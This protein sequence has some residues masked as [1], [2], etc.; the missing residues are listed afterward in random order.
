MNIAFFS[1]L[2]PQRSGISDYS[3]ELLLELS[4]LVEVSL[5]VDGFRPSSVQL[6]ENFPIVDYDRDRSKLETLKEYDAV[7]Y[8][9]GNDHR[10]HAG[11]Y[12]AIK[13]QRGIIV[14][15]DF[16]LQDFFLGL[17]RER[18][19][20]NIYFDEMGVCHGIAASR[21]AEKA[22]AQGV[23]PLAL[24]RPTD[25]PLNCRLARSAEGIIV[26]SEWSRERFEKIAPGV[27]VRRISMPIKSSPTFD[28][29]NR[30][31]T[32]LKLASFG[33]I[34]P[35]KGI[36]Q[37]L[38]VLST[39]RDDCDFEY[40]LVGAENPYFDVRP[41]VETYHLQDR[42]RIT[43]HVSLEEF[44]RHIASTDI[45]L[46]LRERTVGET[47]ASLC[48]I[49]AAGVAVIVSN[50]GSF[51]E[52]PNDAVVKIEQDHLSDRLLRAYLRKLMDDPDLRKR[53]GANARNYIIAEHDVREKARYYADFIKEIVKGRA[54][55][56]FVSSIAADMKLLGI[57]EGDSLMTTLAREITQL[58]TISETPALNGH[59]RPTVLPPGDEQAGSGIPSPGLRLS[60]ISGIDYK[61]A[62]INYP[63]KL[64]AERY[65]Y[66][67][68]KP[69]YNLAN[70]PSKHLGE[71]M[72][73]ETF[74]HFCDFAN[75]AV[76]MAL[77]A[78]RRILD[79]G[80]GSGWLSEYFARLGY[81][82]TGIDISPDLIDIAN[83]R[84]AKQAFPVDHETEL[85]CRFMVHDIETEALGETFDAVVCYDSLHHFEDEHAVIR[86][87]SAMTTYGGVVF[88][89]E[90]DRPEQGSAT[91]EELVEVMRR[92]E[93]LES[94]FT[95]SYLRTLL[96]EN[97]LVV[98]GDYVSVNGL[99]ERDNLEFPSPEI[100][101]LL[102]K[103]VVRLSGQP[104]SSIPNSQQP[105][106][107]RAEILIDSFP[108]EV[109][110]GREI[111]TE[112]FIKNVGPALWLV[113][114]AKRVGSVML[115]L[116]LFDE[117]GGLVWERHGTPPLPYALAEGESVKLKM[118]FNVPFT[119]GIYTIKLDMVAQHVCWFEDAGSITTTAR[120]KVT[121]NAS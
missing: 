102:C 20:M 8:H 77:P 10:Y 35:G 14:F 107:L 101:Y 95:R 22:L 109:T 65:H 27:P 81:D 59:H 41:L 120:F 16:A 32:K 50:V 1:P 110:P 33:L 84:L 80:C 103:K 97:G 91:E 86:N 96:E 19:D 30:S 49:M 99:F 61:R 15:H 98:I 111:E 51:T 9:M 52:L 68:T 38:R 53:I 78:G 72:D 112:L 63:R 76:A 89:L 83:Q 56:K 90:G 47:S 23:L 104:A 119:P 106:G 5:F 116:R 66:L 11:I 55:R 75:M 26:H 108:S 18:K 48:R 3:E 62:A 69:F 92:Y 42:V 39:L 82:V 58:T 24:D 87:L 117:E 28:T 88:I 60:K 29:E 37:I 73:A 74:R 93:T 44:K 67:F 31:S 118:Q 70:K 105:T 25:F 85:R 114:A 100:N 17:A 6:L 12:D 43:G 94:P 115:G 121:T 21:D 79:V 57:S 54:R 64:D 113:G 4:K 46:N 45:A 34:I 2:N 40:T 36:D 13:L 71:G 7:L